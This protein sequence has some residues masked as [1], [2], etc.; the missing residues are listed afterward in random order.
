MDRFIP[1]LLRAQGKT[2]A[3]YGN[4]SIPFARMEEKQSRFFPA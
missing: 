3:S 4:E 1:N 2:F